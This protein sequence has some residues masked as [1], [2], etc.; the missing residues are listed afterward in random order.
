MHGGRLEATTY[1]EFGNGPHALWDYYESIGKLITLSTNDRIPADW[2]GKT[3]RFV[4]QNNSEVFGTLSFTG[5][6]D[7]YA[8]TA[9]QYMP[10]EASGGPIYFSS[11][12]MRKLQTLK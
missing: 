5:D 3:V 7:R 4:S 12:G 11:E 6:T 2:A 10:P 8:I 1:W 9:D